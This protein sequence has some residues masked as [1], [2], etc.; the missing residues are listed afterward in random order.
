MKGFKYYTPTEVVFGKGTE[1]KAGEMLKKYGA[2]KVLVHYGSD[3]IV[4]S[5][6]LGKHT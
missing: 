6:L 3:R 1:L 2:T 5:G 4:K